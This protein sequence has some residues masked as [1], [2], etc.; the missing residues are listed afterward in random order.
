MSMTV[1]L[2]RRKTDQPRMIIPF[3]SSLAAFD[4]SFHDTDD[5]DDSQTSDGTLTLPTDLDTLV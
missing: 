3:R 2:R 5:L 1:R 4:Q